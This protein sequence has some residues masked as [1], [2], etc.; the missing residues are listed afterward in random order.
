MYTN[1]RIRAGHSILILEAEESFL[2]FPLLRFSFKSNM[3]MYI[4]QGYSPCNR[5]HDTYITSKHKTDRVQMLKC[6]FCTLLVAIR[7][8][9]YLP[10]NQGMMYA[11]KISTMINTRGI[12]I[13]M[14]EGI[15]SFT[16]SSMIRNS[17]N[18]PYQ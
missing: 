1:R 11:Q 14:T 12:D 8:P 18:R 3:D 4:N 9:A 16:T 6:S 17:K 5:H 2:S 15:E 13:T 7:V 10:K